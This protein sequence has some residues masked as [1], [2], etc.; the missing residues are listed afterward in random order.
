[1][2]KN[3][4]KAQ[5]NVYSDIDSLLE[6]NTDTNANEGETIVRDEQS[7]KHNE[8]ETVADEIG[9]LNDFIFVVIFIPFFIIFPWQLYNIIIITGDRNT[10][11][12]LIQNIIFTFKENMLASLSIGH[13]HKID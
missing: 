4:Q 10:K 9:C 2:L 12:R 5:G 6:G 13:N 1:V 8:N 3:C 11:S 7:G